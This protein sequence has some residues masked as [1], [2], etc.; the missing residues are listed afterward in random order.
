MTAARRSCLLWPFVATCIGCGGPSLRGAVPIEDARDFAQAASAELVPSEC[1]DGRGAPARPPALRVQRVALADAREALL[2]LRPG[3]DGVVVTNGYD[4][5]R[6]RVFQYVSDDG[7]QPKL[8]HTLLLTPTVP[9]PKLEISDSFTLQGSAD[10]F[11]GTSRTSLLECAL[12]P[13]GAV[14]AA[15]EAPTASP[16]AGSR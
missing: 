13:A 12:V 9:G 15:R 7:K 6:G 2:E 14:P 5:A 8:L 1:R 3:Y 16:P 11:R 4:E 10:D